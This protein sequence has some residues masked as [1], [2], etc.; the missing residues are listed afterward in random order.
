MKVMVRIP[1]R[2]N[3]P[4]DAVKRINELRAMKP[5]WDV[6][7]HTNGFSIAISR[8]EMCK[9]AREANVDFLIMLDDDIIPPSSVLNLPSHNKP[10][11]A[12]LALTWQA[13]Y[14]Q[15]NAYEIVDGVSFQN[16]AR[17]TDDRLL[18]PVYA[19]GG[20]CLCIR[21]DVLWNRALWPLFAERTYPDG[22]IM[23]FGGEDIWFSTQLQA[24]GIPVYVDP[25]VQCEHWRPT[26]LKQTAQVVL[27]GA[28]MP[29]VF[30]A[31]IRGF[32]W[33]LPNV[34]TPEDV[35][36]AKRPSLDIQIQ[37]SPRRA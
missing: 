29:A 2:G 18:R 21:K 11:V 10:M 32:G 5:E 4:M 23:P 19:V 31:D 16:I 34:P 20:A 15:W 3:P 28:E 22:T 33:E 6:D 13:G 27:S 7:W 30:N 9:Q 1:T 8:N 36:E 14:H 12:G 35:L 37:D 25:Q 24:A 26:G 17:W